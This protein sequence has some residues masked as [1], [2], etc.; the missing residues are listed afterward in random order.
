M[1]NDSNLTHRY[2][3]LLQQR[4]TLEGERRIGEMAARTTESS[5]SIKK[6]CRICIPDTAMEYIEEFSNNQHLF[7]NRTTGHMDTNSNNITMPLPRRCKGQDSIPSR[8]PTRLSGTTVKG[9]NHGLGESPVL[10]L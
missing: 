4:H 6:D 2:M 8:A 1:V 10:E 9:L 5:M 7:S 3:D